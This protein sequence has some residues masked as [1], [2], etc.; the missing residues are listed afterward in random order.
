MNF[1]PMGDRVLVNTDPLETKTLSGLFIPDAVADAVNRGTI[2]AVGPGTAPKK[3]GAVIPVDLRVGERI[4]YAPGSGLKVTV[5][6]EDYLVLK[7]E[8]VIAIVDGE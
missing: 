4:L 3:G 6:G 7:E 8:E 1:K 5:G 2:V